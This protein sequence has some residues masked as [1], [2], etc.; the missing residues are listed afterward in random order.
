MRNNFLSFLIFLIVSKLFFFSVNSAEQFN[1]DITEIEILQN[2]D[3]IKGI[4][5]GTVSTNDGII[6]TADTFI[7]QKLLNILSAEGNVTIKDSKKNLEI[8]SN[9]V[10]YEKNKEII[11]TNKNSKV[12][13]GVGKS[14]IADSFK[15]NRKK[16]I[17]DANGNVKIK[18]L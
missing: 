16:N 8:Y 14:I 10:I 12:I 18:I 1:F 5:K 13:Y 2:G 11:T 7:Y 6:I 4:K 3:V 17:L 9:N 15:L